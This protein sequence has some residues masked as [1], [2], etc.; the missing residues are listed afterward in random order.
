MDPKKN[1]PDPSSWDS[2]FKE[3]TVPPTSPASESPKEI[4]PQSTE[5]SPPFNPF[6]SVNNT[7]QP[8]P[9]PTP[10]PMKETAAPPSRIPFENS[11]F[12]D[13]KSISSTPEPIKPIEESHP[14]PIEEIKITPKVPNEHSPFFA[15]EN[16]FNFPN[17][18]VNNPFKDAKENQPKAQSIEAGL[19][20]TR[21]LPEMQ[22]RTMNSDLAS[23]KSSGGNLPEALIVSEKELDTKSPLFK[24]ETTIPQS[25]ANDILVEKKSGLSLPIKTL[26]IFLALIVLGGLGFIIYFLMKD[27][28]FPETLDLSPSVNIEPN[29]PAMTIDRMPPETREEP[30]MLPH[31][32]AFGLTPESKDLAVIQINNYNLV[33]IL[34]AFQGKVSLTRPEDTLQ[35]IVV[36]TPEGQAI[37]S[38]YF[39]TLLPELQGAPLSAALETYFDKD[40]TAFLYYEKGKAYP[41]LIAKKLPN[42][43]FDPELLKN[44]ESASLKNLYLALPKGEI[45]PFK[46]SVIAGVTTR[47]GSFFED[48]PAAVNY[49]LFGDNLIITT[50]NK[51]LFK[52]LDLLR[53]SN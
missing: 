13:P 51:S 29:T 5:T 3:G 2:F 17:S 4:L 12:F 40:F 20:E 50:T 27:L 49:G 7:S 37:F 48:R 15:P 16:P 9:A 23:I 32:S 36:G 33:D 25:P 18:S 26:L 19:P 52:V 35:E 1:N 10:E 30:T 11:K 43:N 22:L 41:G 31:T 46:D 24:P 45:S 44:I 6:A 14:E 38:K 47:Y 42:S 28:F 8:S 53:A 39:L 34:S 21:S